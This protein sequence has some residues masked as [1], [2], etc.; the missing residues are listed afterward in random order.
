MPDA[1]IWYH[2]D[3]KQEPDLMNWLDEVELQAGIRGKLYIRKA[4]EKVNDKTTF[5]ETYGDVS[6]ATIKRIEKL[7]A[8][9]SLFKGIDRHC[10]SFV[11][12]G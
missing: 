6:S 3:D 4:S 11:E 2:A 7:A 8:Q 10:E 12:I 1:F 5:M 9:Q